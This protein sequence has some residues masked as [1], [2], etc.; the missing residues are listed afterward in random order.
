MKKI[1][2]LFLSVSLTILLLVSCTPSSTPAPVSPAQPAAT[3]PVQPAATT[4]PP[5][6]AATPRPAATPAPTAAATP[7]TP[8][9]QG[10]TIEIVAA[11]APGG[12][13]DTTARIVA[14]YLPKYIP[15]NP[16]ILVRNVPGAGGVVAMNTLF[17]R[18]KPDGLTLI[19]GSSSLINNQQ[20]GRETVHYDLRNIKPI[21][22]IGGAGPVVGISKKAASRL[23]DPNAE[24]VIMGTRSGEET[25]N[26]I[27]LFGR[28]FLGWNVKWLT[29]FGGTGEIVL[30]FLRGEVDMFGDGQN[31]KMVMEQGLAETVAQIGIY[32]KGNFK[33]RPDFPDTPTMVE[34]LGDKKPSGIAWQ[35]YM[36][37]L[38]AQ[39]VF[40]FTAAPPKTPD[41]IVKILT[42]AFTQMNKDPKFHEMLV[43]TFA[44]EYEVNIGEGTLDL[45]NEAL[46]VPME[47][48]TYPDTLLKKFDV[49][50]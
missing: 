17:E 9:Y 25:F 47:A 29:G 19:H 39:F 34:V 41:N 3:Q 44:E 24:P 40:K 27:P 33:R 46:N 37:T 35:G 31:V 8:Y 38:A 26:L 11:T 49:I 36:A 45:I 42:D 1:P 22:N 14:S 48:A 32:E 10:R 28:E 16:K 20:R 12:G 2:L 4:P 6:A 15:G 43:K 5:G 13:T 18:T 7:Q 30:A 23:K 50:K 21:G